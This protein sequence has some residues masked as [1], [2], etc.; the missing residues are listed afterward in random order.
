V[1]PR[2]RR[3]GTYLGVLR[4]APLHGRARRPTRDVEDFKEYVTFL[5]IIL[6]ILIYV[7]HD[8]WYGSQLATPSDS[9]R[10]GLLRTHAGL[11]RPAMF[12]SYLT[13]L[14]LSTSGGKRSR[15]PRPSPCG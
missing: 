10:D 3:A 11:Q 12:T 14:T 2:A 7:V 9:A 5:L 15:S 1:V 4:T 8:L 13:R 6:I